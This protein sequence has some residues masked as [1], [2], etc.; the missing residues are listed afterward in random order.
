MLWW[1]RTSE[2]KSASPSVPINAFML[3]SC[4]STV[5]SRRSY[6]TARGA[7]S[8]SKG[9]RTMALSFPNQTRFYDAPRRAVQFWGHDSTREAVFFVTED[10]LKRVQPGMRLDERGLL[11]AFD[12]NR[13]LIHA[14]AAKVYARGRRGS[15]HLDS[16]DFQM[17]ALLS[18]GFDGGDGTND[19]KHG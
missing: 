1:S 19:R 7:V 4:T 13:E 8:S 18:A 17:V 5:D 3:P 12:A 10:A 2:G 6:E 11:G 9:P 14:A 16:T 15:Y